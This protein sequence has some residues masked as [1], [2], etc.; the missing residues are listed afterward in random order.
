MEGDYFI[1]D[2]E[3]EF[4][5]YRNAMDD[6]PMG[7]VTTDGYGSF[8]AVFSPETVEG[9]DVYLYDP[10]YSTVRVIGRQAATGYAD[11]DERF[12]DYQ[13]PE[14]SVKLKE[15]YNGSNQSSNP[16]IKIQVS[17]DEIP[18]EN[19]T[20]YFFYSFENN[21]TYTSIADQTDSDGYV[22][23]I[24]NE[25]LAGKWRW[26][27]QA[28][29]DDQYSSPT[30]TWFFNLNPSQIDPSWSASLE[31]NIQEYSSQITL[32]VATGATTGFD[33]G[34]GDQL[35]PPGFSG[36]EAYL[37]Y[38]NNP[39]T[40]VDFRKLSTSLHPVYYPVNWT[41]KVHTFS[42]T[43]GYTTLS[44][45]STEINTISSNYSVTLY[46][47]TQNVD[48][49]TT[50][51]Y[52]WESEEDSTYSFTI[53]VSGEI[54]ITLGLKAGWNMMSLPVDP[55]DP[56]AAAILGEIG[57][58]QL[59]TWSGTGYVASTEFEAGRGYWLLVLED[60]NVTISGIPVDSLSLNLSPG[61]SMVGGTYAEEQAAD[62]F[63]GFYQL[64]TWT[65][66]GYT[67]ATVFEPGQGYWAL[68]LAET[69]IQLPAK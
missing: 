68:V 59:V 17:R 8:T 10:Y 44:W 6:I 11:Y 4:Y 15:P 61:W 67:P 25:T 31:V 46:T 63:P 69:Q 26:Y 34:I 16:T 14:L 21:D 62:V 40:P 45:N 27:A 12:V 58:Y 54:K 56:S 48:M 35:I 5:L 38:P 20:V 7:S 13:P 9:L 36:V 37:W 53:L 22:T 57:F 19:A 32:G 55:D 24:F 3:Y 43:S 66:T 51:S 65:G 47:L 60:V 50:H 28:F 33:P 29:K 1:P 39:V 49:R 42:G 52:S 23:Y 18:V 41:L 64:V 2:T 30:D